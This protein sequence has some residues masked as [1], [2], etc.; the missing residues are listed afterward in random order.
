MT[1]RVDAGKQALRTCFLV[2][3]R[4]IDLAGQEQPGQEGAAGAPT[5]PK[6]GDTQAAPPQTQATPTPAPAQ[7]A[8]ATPAAAGDGAAGAAA[9]DEDVAEC[10]MCGSIIPLSAPMCPVCG[11]EFE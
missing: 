5:A 4:A 7:A 6:P 11:A 10:Y 8:A 2:A 3:G 9:G 1:R